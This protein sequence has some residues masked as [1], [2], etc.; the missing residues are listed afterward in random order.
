MIKSKTVSDFIEYARDN[1]KLVCEEPLNLLNIPT[2]HT[3]E[4]IAIMDRETYRLLPPDIRTSRNEMLIIPFGFYLGE[5]LIKLFPEF[6]WD[7]KPFTD[8]FNVSIKGE[9]NGMPM[10]IKPFRK[11][12]NFFDDS[13]NQCHAMYETLRLMKEESWSPGSDSKV[14][15]NLS[16]KL[17]SVR[18]RSFK[19]PTD[20]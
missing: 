8:L 16:P 17:K 3:P 14:H 7:D 2:D 4:S 6:S 18:I 15:T 11:I 13:N 9:I 10:E 12:V 5:T 1:K 20:V 19:M